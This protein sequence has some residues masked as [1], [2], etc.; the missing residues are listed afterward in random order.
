MLRFRCSAPVK[1]AL[2]SQ[3]VRCSIETL[4]QRRGF[5]HFRPVQ[6]V[7]VRR[8][9][10]LPCP[11]FTRV[12]PAASVASFQRRFQHTQQAKPADGGEEEGKEKMTPEEEEEAKKAEERAR[13]EKEQKEEQGFLG[14]FVAL[15]RDFIRFPAIYNTPNMM[16][17]ILFTVFCLCSTGSN[18]EQDWWTEQ[19]G[20]DA[21]FKPWAW[22]F[23]SFLTNNFM[24]M[25]FGMMLIHSMCHSV[26][27]TL[28][29]VRLIAYM[30]L[31]SLLSGVIMWAG[32]NYFGYTKEKQFGPWDAMAAM[33]VMQYLHQGFTP[34]QILNAFSGW[35]RYAC[36][37]GFI[38]I[39][40]FD[41][42]P[43]TLGTVL[44]FMLCG[45]VFRIP[46][47]VKVV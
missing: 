22:I 47:P 35:I 25:V 33:F 41:W 6:S 13:F 4:A 14:H 42:Q 43:V 3:F 17:F 30:G 31:V 11:F 15:R 16:N 28:G 21:T 27:P 18:V 26:L 12:V 40:Y 9:G 5:V 34:F 23:H 19:F 38:S 45:T 24:S 46:I 7:L 1:V 37:V 20:I 8:C 32:N 10:S 29:A 39:G 36:F 44:G 2:A